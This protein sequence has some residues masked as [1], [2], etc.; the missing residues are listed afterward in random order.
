MVLFS[1]GIIGQKVSL[2]PKI[3]VFLEFSRYLL[4][5][6]AIV[7]GLFLKSLGLSAEF[8][9]T[10]NGVIFSRGHRT[11]SATCAQN[12]GFPAE[13]VFKIFAVRIRYT[14]WV[15]SKTNWVRY[16]I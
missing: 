6:F 12:T 14:T 4:S 13:G 15:I 7:V 3:L 16:I 8:N 11:K 1:V 5:E 2:P 10:S 9:S